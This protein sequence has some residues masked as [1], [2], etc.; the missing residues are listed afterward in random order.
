MNV[1]ITYACF[2]S[3]LTFEL[4]LIISRFSFAMWSALNKP[5]NNY[6]FVIYSSSVFYLFFLLLFLTL[7]YRFYFFLTSIKLSKWDGENSDR[8]NVKNK[9]TRKV[10]MKKRSQ[11]IELI[12]IWSL[13]FQMLGQEIP[14]TNIAYFSNNSLNFPCKAN[15]TIWIVVFFW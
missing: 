1:G 3:I 9:G 11:R 7:P 2:N 8:K 5:L 4:C 14:K 13:I 12:K 15:E 10:R 6:L